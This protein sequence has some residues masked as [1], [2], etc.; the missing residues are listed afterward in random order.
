MKR[1]LLLLLLIG[2]VF[3]QGNNSTNSSSGSDS[4]PS[5][6]VIDLTPLINALTALPLQIVSAFFSFVVDGLSLSVVSLRDATLKFMFSSPDVGFLCGVYNGVLAM[7]DSLFALVMM[8]LALF[9]I[10]RSGDVEGRMEAKKWMENMI[11]MAVVLAFSFQIF[12]SLLNFNTYLTNSLATQSMGSIFGPP[13]NPSSVIFAFLMLS[14]TGALGILTFLTLLLRYIMI[15]F[16]LL[17]FPVAIFMYF[18]PP[19][20]GWGK[21]FLKIILVCIFMTTADALV[22]V[23][24]AAMFGSSDPILSDSIVRS[25]AALI[26]F[27]ALG[28][29]NVALVVMAL[30]SILLPIGNAAVKS[31]GFMVIRKAAMGV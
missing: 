1:F 19:L 3:A 22:M 10:L 14:T 8:G 11:V 23:G 4:P 7:I 5:A 26:G 2:F 27:G 13:K 24:L 16:M 21:T 15:P 20:Q 25:F 17:L 9:F 29:V 6:P 30:I 12:G 18:I 31:A 28:L